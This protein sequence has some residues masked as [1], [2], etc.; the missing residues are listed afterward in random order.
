MSSENRKKSEKRPYKQKAR[1]R[2]KEDVHQRI[3]LAAVHL[4]GT[5]G[6]SKTTMRDIARHAGVRRA[7][8]YNHFPTDFELYNACSSHWFSENPPPDP[9]QWAEISDPKERITTALESLYSYYN[10]GKE[11]LGNVLRDTPQIPALQEILS[12]KWNPLL[13]MMIGILSEGWKNPT[14]GLDDNENRSLI[15]KASL[16]V[17]LDFF[18]WQ[19]L[20][21]SGLSDLQTAQVAS[22][23]IEACAKK[24][25]KL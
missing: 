12:Q 9:S 17:V 1:A 20:S 11:M 7:T 24:S 3:T 13:E 6:P 14:S 15:L 16:R 22:K 2:Q 5:V 23:W 10:S 19:T 4:H 18:T 25:V 8:I 21:T